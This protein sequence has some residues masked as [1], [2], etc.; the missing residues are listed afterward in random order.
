MALLV[1]W[2]YIGPANLGGPLWVAVTEGNSMEPGIH[3]GSVA[4]VRRDS[5]IEAGDIILYRSEQTGQDVLHRVISIEDGRYVTKGDNNDWVDPDRPTADDIKGVYLGHIS[6]GS[7]WLGHLQSPLVSAVLGGI[8][9]GVFAMSLSSSTTTGRSRF[10]RSPG[11][12]R[13]IQER[14]GAF[15]Q[16]LTADTVMGVL[17]AL[18]AAG[19]VFAAWLW[20]QPASEMAVATTNYA[21]GAD[22]SYE[23]TTG[24]EG[25]LPG[26]D[27]QEQALLGQAVTGQPIF[28]SVTPIVHVQMDYSLT[29]PALTDVRGTARLFVVLRD[30]LTGWSREADLVPATEFTGRT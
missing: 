14:A 27:R 4:F 17:M 23:T 3:E 2:S 8:T 25:V 9:L 19:V 29:A 6:G 15:A 24:W 28:P 26:R 20:T 22:W 5:H 11:A 13:P 1:V 12:L 10:R 16:S 30:D 21:H 18:V 7:S